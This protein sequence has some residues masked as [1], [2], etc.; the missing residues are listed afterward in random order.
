MSKNKLDTIKLF[1]DKIQLLK[2]HNKLYFINDN[3]KISDREYD[4]LKKELVEL[5]SQ[6]D[7]LKD[8]NLLEKIVGSP[9]TNKFSKINLRM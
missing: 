3:P 9:P 4:D 5:E 8:L 1:K 6:N 2:K 7:F